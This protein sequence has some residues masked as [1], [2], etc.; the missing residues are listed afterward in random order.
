MPQIPVNG[1]NF[2]VLEQG[3]GPAVVLLHGFPMDAR[4]WEAQIAALSSSYRVIAP[5]LRGFGQSINADPFTI[6]SLAHD[7]QALL[8]QMNITPCVLGGLSMG[9]YIAL[10]YEQMCPTDL[11]GL[12]LIDTKAEADSTDAKANRDKSI[13]LVQTA[14]VKAVA[15]QMLPRLLSP[16]TLQSRPHIVHRLRQ[17]MESVPPATI[18]HAQ[19]AMRDRPDCTAMLPSIANP[20]LIINGEDDVATPPA[21]ARLMRQAI[22]RAQL[23]LIPGAGHLSPME[24][25][26]LVNAALRDFL[27]QCHGEPHA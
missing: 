21:M 13:E 19:R 7:I 14:G 3:A 8:R 1:C 23:A 27:Q 5:D 11:K 4:I 25:P 26:D 9:G 15:D 20:V 2:N 6:L 17:I 10:A 22:P 18:I 24:Q 16:A 12:L